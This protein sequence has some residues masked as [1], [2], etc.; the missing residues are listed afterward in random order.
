MVDRL[1]DMIISGGENIY[2]AELESV[3]ASLPGGA[4]VAGVGK[5]DERW[6]EVPIAFVVATQPGATD[7]ASIVEACRQRLAGF[8]CVKSVHMLEALPRSSVGKVLKR[9][10][11]A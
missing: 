6:G 8:K 5:A 7:E 4:E 2:P 10:L 11:L 3:I 1:K 9:Q